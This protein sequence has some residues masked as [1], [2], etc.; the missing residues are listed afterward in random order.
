[1]VYVF[2]QDIRSTLVPL[3]AIVV[4]LIGTFAFMTVAGF[5]INLITLFA[6]VL[7]IGTVVD[8]AIVVVEAVQ[9]RFD[10]GYKS[11]Y[12]ASMDAM[13]GLTS[14][15]VST[16]LVFMGVFIPVSFMSGTSGTFYTQFGLTMAAAVGISTVNALT[17][18]PGALRYLIEALHQR[19]RH[20]K[21]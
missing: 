20:P 12:M 7:V 16:S 17:V 13:K 3:V 1:M 10:V 8:D 2:L 21:E 19:G 15:I 4:S 11:S 18:K 14:A 6:L 9:A 5:S